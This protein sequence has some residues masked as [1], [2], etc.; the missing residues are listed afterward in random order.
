[1]LRRLL[2]LSAVMAGLSFSAAADEGALVTFKVLNL[3]TA[4]ELAQATLADCRK[5]G[6][7]VAVAVVDRFG[8]VQVMLRDRFAGAHTP[9]T[10]RRK[11]W[12][13]VS[14]RANTLEMENLIK[15]GELTPGVRFVEGAL[16]VGGGVPVLA[17]GSIVAG[18]GVSGAPGGA[19]DDDCAQA[20]IETI[21]DK[22]A[23]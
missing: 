10:A 6:F 21:S 2:T 3:E 15:S 22:L 4:T 20:G 8:N 1:M 7:Q 14:F 16:V 13:A 23:F 18:I 19:A 9:E 11:A 12:S 5:R 17:A